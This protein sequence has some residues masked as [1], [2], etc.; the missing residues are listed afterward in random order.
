MTFFQ[1]VFSQFPP[2]GGLMIWDDGGQVVASHAWKWR[3]IAR[4][5][6]GVA[7]LDEVRRSL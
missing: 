6:L 3:N 2:L 4:C 5:F 7:P 1:S